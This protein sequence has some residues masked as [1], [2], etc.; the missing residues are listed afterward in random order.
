MFPDRENQD[1][2]EGEGERPSSAG[3]SGSELHCGQMSCPR[4]RLLMHSNGHCSHSNP[5]AMK[6]KMTLHQ[7]ADKIKTSGYLNLLANCIDNFTH[8]LAVA[9]SFLVSRKVGFLTT[10]AILLHE[11]PH[12]VGKYPGGGGCL[13]FDCSDLCG[14]NAA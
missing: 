12:E 4:E 13:N 9:G 8:G 1:D 7:P 6:Q 5:S 11:I 14:R 10:L 3:C 2:P